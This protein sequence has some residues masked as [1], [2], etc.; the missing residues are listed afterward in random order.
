MRPRKTRSKRSKRTLMIF[1][2]LLII[3]FGV[4]AF[5]ANQYPLNSFDLKLAGNIQSFEHPA[6]TKFMEL[7]TTIGST[8]VCIILAVLV[9]LFLYFVLGHRIELIFFIGALGGSAVANQILKAIFHRERPSVYRLIEETGY[10]FPSGHSMGA[11]ALYGALAFLLWR[12]TSTRLGRGLLIV[13]S[14]FMIVMICI[15]RVYLGVHYPTDIIGALM[16]SGFWLTLMIW[17]FQSYM[18]NRKLRSSSKLQANTN[19]KLNV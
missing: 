11:L 17:I 6:L 10:S 7:F 9:M 14:S 5:I 15:S 4:L 2:F 16:V 3:G 18:E 19:K 1:S 13:L 12:H 8:K